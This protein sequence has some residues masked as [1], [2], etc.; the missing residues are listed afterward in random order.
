MSCA[1]TCRVGVFDGEIASSPALHLLGSSVSTG[2][3]VREGAD[4]PDVYRLCVSMRSR[5]PRVPNPVCGT[6]R[7][8][9]QKWA[10]AWL[11]WALFAIHSS[12]ALAS[13]IGVV[14]LDSSAP[15]APGV[16]W[17]EAEQRTL[18]ELSA[19]GLSVISVEASQ[20]GST[21]TF[22]ALTA[23]AHAQHAVAGLR[24]VRN[25]DEDKVD[26]WLVDEVTGKASLRHVSTAKLDPSEAVALV[27]LSVVELLNA[28]LLELRAG[29]AIHGTTAPTPA[30]LRMVDTSLGDVP[31]PYLF[32][33]G[34]GASVVGSP[35]GLG[36]MGGPAL[37]LGLGV[38][39]R[40]AIAAD[41]LATPVQTT[42]E[43]AAGTAR[44]GVGL[45]RLYAVLRGSLGARIEP[46]LGLGGGA[47]WVWAHGDAQDRY[48]AH[49][50][51]TTVAL[52][53]AV[54]GI[55][56]RMSVSWRLRLALSAGF[57]MPEVS[58]DLA[59]DRIATAGRP[60]LDCIVGIEWIVPS[61]RTR[62]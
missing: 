29:H 10:V 57:A 15:P 28:S 12:S 47:L 56:A 19:V 6:D 22:S 23:A 9:A 33:L 11:V 36:L 59:G 60:L 52:A 40:F 13:N 48:T 35:G 62:P 24:L 14:V 21:D 34:V 46:E 61:E 7:S 53:S 17:P 16:R 55:A 58:I 38:S 41:V 43:G 30:V 18:A 20:V 5:R 31:V 51:V 4:L 45:A 26:I 25:P 2:S 50:D 27:A 44:V 37:T 32:T 39:P 3:R 8:A 42:V 54:A 49:N 1:R